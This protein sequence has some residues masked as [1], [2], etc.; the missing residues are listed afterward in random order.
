M[1]YEVRFSEEMDP[2]TVGDATELYWVD[3]DD[4]TK[5]VMVDIT[6]SPD[7]RT[8]TLTPTSDLRPGTEYFLELGTSA[9][10]PAGN[11]LFPAVEY[12]FTTVGEAPDG[13]DGDDDGGLPLGLILGLLVVIIVVLVLVMLLRMRG[14]GPSQSEPG[15]SR[16]SP[17]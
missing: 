4:D 1:V 9:T 7:G 13:D 11:Q 3:K 14:P 17:P 15:S 10:D 6:W 2:V 16:E 5:E 8:M 12:S